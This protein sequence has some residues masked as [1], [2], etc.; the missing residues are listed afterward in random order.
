MPWWRA[1]SA[2]RAR[3]SACC[4]SIVGVS[5]ETPGAHV[6]AGTFFG[7]TASRAAASACMSRAPTSG[8]RRPR[9]PHGAVLIGIHVQRTAGV[10]TLRLPG[11]GLAVHPAPAPHDAPHVLGAPSPAHRPQRLLR[12]PPRHAGQPPHPDLGPL[13]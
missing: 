1:V 4:C 6:P 8:A 12:L 5:W 11:L 13:P 2:R 3:A 7:Y 10:L 9:D